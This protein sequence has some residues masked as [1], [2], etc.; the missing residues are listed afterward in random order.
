MRIRVATIKKDGKV[1]GQLDFN[2]ET[3]N[4][5]KTTND[6]GIEVGNAEDLTSVL[7]GN[8]DLSFEDENIPVGSKVRVKSLDRQGEIVGYSATD[9]KKVLVKL[10]DEETVKGEYFPI[11]DLE[12]IEKEK[13][14]I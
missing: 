2:T 11:D 1:V 10:Q 14:K 12:I 4:Y 8:E 6:G 5:S 7:D 13:E 3:G 9:P